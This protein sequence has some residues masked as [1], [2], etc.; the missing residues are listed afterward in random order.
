MAEHWGHREFFDTLIVRDVPPRFPPM[1]A[2][3]MALQV[4]E[5]H[6]CQRII[7]DVDGVQRDYS[8]EQVLKARFRALPPGRGTMGV[9]LPE[10]RQIR[11]QTWL[12][13]AVS[14][15]GSGDL[16]KG[17]EPNV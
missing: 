6:H 3:I 2:A 10:D 12:V 15:G 17:D 16:P 11:R 4:A 13:G 14:D 9:A 5:R 8:I 7:V 1:A